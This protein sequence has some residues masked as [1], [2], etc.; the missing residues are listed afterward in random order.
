MFHFKIQVNLIILVIKFHFINYLSDDLIFL[1]IIYYK[2]K[3]IASFINK[4][5]YI[6][7]NYI[8]SSYY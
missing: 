7:K 5:V 6:L 8:I 4:S 2:N 3:Y 1:T